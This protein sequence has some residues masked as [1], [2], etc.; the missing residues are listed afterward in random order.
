MKFRNNISKS[1]SVKKDILN[2]VKKCWQNNEKNI[3]N[4]INNLTRMYLDTKHIT[5]YLDSSTSH[6]L[7]GHKTIILGAKGGLTKDDILMVIS[8]EL[9]HIYYWREIKKD[10]LTKSS[11]GS[12]RKEEWNLSEVTASLITDE[13]S[14]KKFWPTSKVYVYPEVKHV[15]KKVNVFWKK[16]DFNYFLK[17]AY[18]RINKQ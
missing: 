14:L 6:S 12:E 16:G 11:M 18:N 5:C 3:L 9:F 15:Y 1:K 2:Y 17:N 7:Y 8:H 13:P 4:E 10:R